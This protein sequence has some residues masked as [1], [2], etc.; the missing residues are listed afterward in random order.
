M[1]ANDHSPPHFH[2]R[3]AEFSAQ[4]RLD[5]ME[6]IEGEL[7]ARALRMVREWARLHTAELAED[8]ELSRST[9]SGLKQIEPLR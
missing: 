9:M 2:V 1:Y 4:L 3:Y 5:T 8:W 7:P 6:A